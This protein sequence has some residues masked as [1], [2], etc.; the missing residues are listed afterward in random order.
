MKTQ[1][2]MGSFKAL[3]R[4]GI[5]RAILHQKETLLLQGVEVTD[6]MEKDVT[7]VHINTILPNSLFTA[8]KAK[9][10]KKK[11]IYYGHSTMEDFRNS[12]KLSNLL[13]PLF[14]VWIKYCY[15]KGDIIIT[16]TE[17]SKKILDGYK[18]KRNVIALSNGIDTEFFS[19]DKSEV[20]AFR[21]KYDIKDGEKVVISVGHYIERKG[22]IDFVETARKMPDVKFIWYGFTPFSVVPSHV[23][24]AIKTAPSNVNFAGYVSRDELRTAYRSADLYAFFSH[25]ETEGIVILEAL[26]CEIPMVIRDIPVYDDWL[27]DGINVHKSQSNE[28]FITKITSILDGTAVDLVKAG[29][30]VADERSIDSIGKK[31]KA[32]YEELENMPTKKELKQMKKEEKKKLKLQKQEEKKQNK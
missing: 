14:K 12:F 31:L 26:A 20:Q 21:E 23:K 28:E 3:E 11:V 7:V 30:M 1:I 2:Y 15:N 8:K 27:E 32:I 13:A 5:A 22:V 10:K 24:H 29:K 17:Y 19:P 9:R 16:P 6:K 18:L 25:E 4:S